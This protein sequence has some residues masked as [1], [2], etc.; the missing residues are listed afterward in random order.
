MLLSFGSIIP[1]LVPY[2]SNLTNHTFLS[3]NVKATP[4]LAGFIAALMTD[5]SLKNNP[6]KVRKELASKFAIDIGEKGRD[7]STGVG[8]VTFLSRT[9]FHQFF[10]KQ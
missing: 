9:E 6:E 10:Q 7:N 8:F 1:F 3:S 5:G 4:H 2:A